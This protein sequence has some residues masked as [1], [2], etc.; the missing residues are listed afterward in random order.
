MGRGILEP[1]L[2]AASWDLWC[3]PAGALRLEP[4]FLTWNTRT[5]V[6]ASWGPREDQWPRDTRA[7]P[8]TWSR[9]FASC[10]DAPCGATPSS[11]HPSPATCL[12]PSLYFLP[13]G[14]DFTNP[15]RNSSVMREVGEGR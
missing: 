11:D 3:D 10:A 5:P 4:Q 9:G 7:L 15:C 2:A 8:S 1:A 13:C 12:V 6:P 14:P